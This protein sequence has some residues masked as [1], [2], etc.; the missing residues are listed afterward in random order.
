[1][2]HA[3]SKHVF[4]LITQKISRLLVDVNQVKVKINQENSIIRTVE[5]C[6]VSLVAAA[7]FFHRLAY[8]DQGREKLLET[9]PSVLH[10]DFL[11]C[12][13]F[14]Q[15]DKIG[16]ISKPVL[17]VCGEE[18]KMTPVKFGQFL[19]S[20]L[21]NANLETIPDAGHMVMLEFP[22]AVTKKIVSF[23]KQV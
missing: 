4:T 19:A 10:G 15:R 14:D 1:M 12:N 22:E 20:N 6:P 8:I 2:P 18:D 21:S 9:R 23:I 11:A 13:N 16:Q 5:Q 17:V 7:N 3:F